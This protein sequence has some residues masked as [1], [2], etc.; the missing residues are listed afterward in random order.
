MDKKEIIKA[1]EEYSG[2]KAKY[3]GP[4]SFAYQI[5]IAKEIFVIDRA[6]LI[7]TAAGAQVELENLLHGVTEK[8][9][10]QHDTDDVAGLEVVLP[11]KGHTGVTLK[12]LVNMFYS[13]QVLIKKAFEVDDDIVGANFVESI[14]NIT[15]Q[16][17]EDFMIA[18]CE[19]EEGHC[20]GIEFNFQDNTIVFKFFKHLPNHE[21]LEAFSKLVCLLNQSA[22]AQKYASPKQSATDNEK[23]TMRTWLLRL[24][25][26]G[27]EYKKAR[28]AILNNLSGNGAFRKG[29][30]N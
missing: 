27:A 6:G 22:M 11:M 7:I 1:L 20:S 14:N 3:M 26:I 5:I 16:S 21:K 13:K 4:P 30:H 9:L 25:F 8:G 15:I 12:Y 10:E 2:V 19:D 17:L 29:K 18:V 24:G 23:Y 28:E